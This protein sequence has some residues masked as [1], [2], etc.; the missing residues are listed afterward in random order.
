MLK[1]F[2]YNYN[3]SGTHQPEAAPQFLPG[4]EFQNGP[5]ATLPSLPTG[6]SPPILMKEDE[7]EQELII[8]EMVTQTVN[9]SNSNLIQPHAG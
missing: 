6:P 9:Y 4:A 2:N 8:E 3:A 7:E 1:V 5:V